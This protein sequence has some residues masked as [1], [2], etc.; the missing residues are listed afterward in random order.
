MIPLAWKSIFPVWILVRAA[1]IAL[2]L[3]PVLKTKDS[4]ESLDNTANMRAPLSR[5][6]PHFACYYLNFGQTLYMSTSEDSNFIES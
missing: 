3:P 1:A 5:K 4:R 2:E 6:R